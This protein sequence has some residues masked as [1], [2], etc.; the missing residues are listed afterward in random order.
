[1][2]PQRGHHTGAG[3]LIS[4]YPLEIAPYLL[5][6]VD[7]VAG[8]LYKN[9]LRRVFVS[10]PTGPGVCARFR[11]ALY[12]LSAS[13]ALEPDD[14]SL[15]LALKRRDIGVLSFCGVVFALRHRCR[16]ALSCIGSPSLSVF[17]KRQ[18]CLF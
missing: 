2:K 10:A 8:P 5:G 9:S 4:A 18:R 15:C 11:T 6:I 14:L 1:M 17:Q 16:F 3:A 13:G 12:P 7:Q